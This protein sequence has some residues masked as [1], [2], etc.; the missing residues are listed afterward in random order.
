M[1]KL[2]HR[3]YAI[4][5]A[6]LLGVGGLAAAGPAAAANFSGSLTCPASTVVKS[7]GYKG[8]TG[9]ITVSA[10]GRSY[11]DSTSATGLAITVKGA[12]STGTWSV[13]GSGATS[14]YGSCGT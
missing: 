4:S 9:S 7:S 8:G 5:A 13:S 11:T 6:V 14:G 10:P 2:S 3:I 12:Y 1:R